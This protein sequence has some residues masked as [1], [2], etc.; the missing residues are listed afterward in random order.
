MYKAVIGLGA[1]LGNPKEQLQAAVD[2]LNRL[3]GTKVADCSKLYITK[4]VGYDNQP[5]FLNCVVLVET[6]LSPEALLGAGLGIEAAMGRI[7]SIKNGPRTLD[8]DLLLVEGEKREG[9]ELNLPH[10]R[11]GER[12]FVLAPLADLFPEGKAFDYSFADKLDAL[13]KD[14]VTAC[15]GRLKIE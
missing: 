7:R 6:A 15:A 11:M 2:S 13:E 12:A 3:P 1:N 10:P 8:V 4:P 14:G 9:E 5:D